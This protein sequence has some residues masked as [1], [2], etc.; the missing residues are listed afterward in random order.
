MDGW[1]DGWVDGWANGRVIEWVYGWVDEW[2]YGWVDGWANV[3]V[4][5]WV[6]GWVYGW[7]DGWVD[8][9][10][11]ISRLSGLVL[12]PDFTDKLTWDLHGYGMQAADVA[13]KMARAVLVWLSALILTSEL[14]HPVLVYCVRALLCRCSSASTTTPST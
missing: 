10:A 13:C 5:G 6:D 11:Q 1:V 4:D 2:V 3:W 9:T 12:V 8:G 14:S 7:V